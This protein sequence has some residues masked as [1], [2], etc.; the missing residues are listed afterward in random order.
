MKKSSAT[1]EKKRPTKRNRSGA[2]A[3]QPAA[4]KKKT[5]NTWVTINKCGISDDD[6]DILLTGRWLNDVHIHAAHQLMKKDCHLGG[7][8]NPVHGQ[9][10]SFEP[11]KCDM[12]QILHSAGNHW[13]TISNVGVE[14]SNVVRVY[15]TIATPHKEA[16]SFTLEN[17]GDL[18]TYGVC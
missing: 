2:E 9:N 15:D 12:V 14:A 18:H 7:M 13:L 10:L 16:D 6:K 1:S 17:K 11:V 5:D 8:Q 4:K 3:D